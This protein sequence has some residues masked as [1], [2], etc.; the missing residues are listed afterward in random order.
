MADERIDRNLKEFNFYGEGK[1]ESIDRGFFITSLRNPRVD[2][3]FNR[4]E[5]ISAK[6]KDDDRSVEVVVISNETRKLYEHSTP[7][8]ALDGFFSAEHA[9]DGMSNGG[10]PGY[11]NTT[12]ESVMMAITFIKKESFD[13]LSLPQ[14]E[15]LITSPIEELMKKIEFR[16]LF[17]PTICFWLTDLGGT[18]R[19]WSYFLSEN[20]LISVDE[21]FKMDEYKYRGSD[22]GRRFFKEYPKA[23]HELSIQP[24]H[25]GFNELVLGIFT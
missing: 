13:K 7:V 1:A 8:L 12:P 11:E 9:A 10:Y 18:E 14:K 25:E 20:E 2:Y 24:G 19:D 15:D 3:Q 23:L 17:L 6:C 5:V 4:G 21:A 16:H 22:T